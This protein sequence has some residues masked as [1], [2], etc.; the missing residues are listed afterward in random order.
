MTRKHS[1]KMKLAAFLVGGSLVAASGGCVTDNF[2]VTQ[3]DNT[4][5]S[6]V[7]AVVGNTVISAI[8]AAFGS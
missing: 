8:D 1:W 3:A 5:S 6:I 7:G 2:W 4:L